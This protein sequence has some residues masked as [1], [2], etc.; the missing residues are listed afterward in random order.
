MQNSSCSNQNVF[1][2]ENIDTNGC[3]ELSEKK[4]IFD[5]N[6]EYVVNTPTHWKRSFFVDENS[7]VLTFADT[8]KQLDQAYV[9]EVGF[10]KGHLKWIRPK[11]RIDK[12]THC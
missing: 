3:K 6:N 5:I 11:V 2:Q 1:N 10:Y 9:L 12:K 7:S 8:T 4:E